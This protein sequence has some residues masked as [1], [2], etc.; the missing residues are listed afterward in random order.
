MKKLLLLPFLLALTTACQDVIELDLNDAAPKL[1]IDAFIELNEDGTTTTEVK[2]TRSAP[3]YQEEITLVPDAIVR[4]LSEDGSTFNLNYVGNGVYATTSLN[5]LP[6]VAYTLE[7]EDN[8]ATYTATEELVTT[9]PFVGVEEELIEGFGETTKITAFYN[10][11]PNE[12]NFYLFSYRD[13]ENFQTDIGDDV[14]FA[15]NT[16]LTVFFIDELEP[17]TPSQITIKGIDRNCF[18]FY[19]VLLQQAGEGG[20]GGPFSTPPATVRGN[21]INATNK[22]QFP[23]GYFRV[24]QVFRVDY[25]SL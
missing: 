15:G 12:E 13:A 3:F 25:T 21:V 17:Q 1:V 9:V 5:V 8:G 2:L 20:A 14:F 6:D 16:A 11:P 19:E 7:I 18:R 23:F 10:D 4:I 22:A 24:S